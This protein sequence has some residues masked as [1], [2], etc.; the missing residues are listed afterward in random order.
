LD[1]LR[2][3]SVEALLRWDHPILGVIEPDECIPILEQTGQIQDEGRW[4]LTQACNQTA[5]RRGQGDRVDMSVNVSAR[6]LDHDDIVDHI[7]HALRGSGLAA[8]SLI[9]EVTE[10]ALMQNADAT[11]SRLRAINDL[12][13]GY[14]SLAYLQQ[15]PV[16]CLKIDRRFVDEITTGARDRS[17]RGHHRIDPAPDRVAEGANRH[18]RAG[19]SDRRRLAPL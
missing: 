14:S 7:C 11:A 12:G 2:L 13:T 18:Q 3:V 10:T 15:F 16:N 8:T 1:D 5:Q 6:Q 9:V 17:G 19:R 4:V